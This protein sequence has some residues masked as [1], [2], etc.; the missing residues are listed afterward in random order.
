MLY[1]HG[2]LKPATKLLLDAYYAC[3]RT[4]YIQRTGPQLSTINYSSVQSYECRCVCTYVCV[5][6]NRLH[7]GRVV[8]RV[9]YEKC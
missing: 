9:L 5:Y 6:L 4:P 7:S 3:K 2:D 1:I 8:K